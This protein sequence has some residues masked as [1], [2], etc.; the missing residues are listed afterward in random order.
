M[1]FEATIAITDIIKPM[2]GQDHKGKNGVMRSL[3]GIV[4]GVAAAIVLVIGLVSISVIHTFQ[5]AGDTFISF[6]TG[7]FTSGPLMLI[8]IVAAFVG[9]FIW[10]L[11]RT[12]PH[13]N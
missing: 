1:N 5:R 10:T 3:K 11:K 6:E 8:L 4:V 7:E 9:G 2:A 13:L 12:P